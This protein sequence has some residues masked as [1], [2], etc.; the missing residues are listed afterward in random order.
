MDQKENQLEEGEIE[1][2]EV[3]T[4]V[5]LKRP[6]TYSLD[7]P[8]KRF[9]EMG[10]QYSD[11][12]DELKF[13]ESDSDSDTSVTRMKKVKRTKLIPKR[14]GKKPDFL[15][16]YDI[17]STRAQED[18]LAETMVGCDVSLK[19]RSRH[20]ESYD[21]SM[22][23]VFYDQLENNK[24]NKRTQS[25][26]KDIN[27]KPR[28]TCTQSQNQVK[29][30][31]RKIPNLEVD[32]NSKEEDIVKDIASKLNEERDD[33]I[34]KVIQVMG[35]STCIEKFKE[36]QQIE[37]EGGMPIMNLT[38][39][40]TPGGV[41]L[42]LVRNDYNITPDQINQIFAEARQKSLATKKDLKKQRLQ[43]LKE[44]AQLERNK[45]LPELLTRA[46]IFA[47]E[48][49]G[50]TVASSDDGNCPPPSPETDH[51]ESGDNM[52]Q[53]ALESHS[54]LTD[55]NNSVNYVSDPRTKLKTYDDDFLEI[56][57]E[58]DMDVF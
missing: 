6:E 23:K 7:A 51:Q 19:D 2:E 36:T 38:R 29:G 4:Y 15:K 41:F 55:P 16:K 43:K 53:I 30:N 45:L 56:H 32:E 28:K 8:Q 33:L 58:N 5:P 47:K 48:N 44:K 50:K 17:W 35:K 18:V 39:R 54:Q 13:S 1:D 20:A 37:S 14:K 12:E 22:A 26:M 52:D 49:I 46:E 57:Y 24:G 11:S 34:L 10:P 40:R 31:P 21:F 9:T 42:Y 3:D 27:F 25:E